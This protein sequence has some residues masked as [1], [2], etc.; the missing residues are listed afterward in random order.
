MNVIKQTIK[1]FDGMRVNC[2]DLDTGHTAHFWST[3]DSFI[4]T[5]SGNYA[6]QK[7]MHKVLDAIR[8]FRMSREVV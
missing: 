1:R 6:T 5:K 8:A 3:G 2:Y 4:Y 7:T